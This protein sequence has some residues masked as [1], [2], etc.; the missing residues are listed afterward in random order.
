[1]NY[2]GNQLEFDRMFSTEEACVDFLI[3]LRWPDGFTCPKC[4]NIENYWRLAGREIKCKRCNHK[5]SVTAGTIFQDSRIDLCILFRALWWIIAQKNG[6]SAKGVQKILGIGSYRTAWT[7]LHKFRRLMI[8]PGR[9]KLSGK[10]E[11]D[12]TFVG[13]AKE[14]KRGRGAS[15]KDIVIIAVEVKGKATGRIRLRRIMDCSVEEIRSF[16][17]DNVEQG[18]V[19]VTDGWPSYL[20]LSEEGYIHDITKATVYDSEELLPNVHRIAS[21]LKRWLIGTHQ[22][23]TTSKHIEYYLDEYT[24]RYN[25][26]TSKSRG[27]LFQRLMEQA[28]IHE[29]LTNKNMQIINLKSG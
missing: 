20:F 15:G 29:P 12:E 14:G 13:G 7:W 24:F 18:S 28:M 3:K 11:I 17:E 19:I 10:V 25:R 26:R 6:V 22:N 23:Y 2:P 8:L 27:L 9:E 5:L 4:K 16:I 1:M 21:L